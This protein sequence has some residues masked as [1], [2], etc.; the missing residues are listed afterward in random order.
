[1]P[2]LAELENRISLLEQ[3]LQLS[4]RTD[5]DIA[6]GIDLHSLGNVPTCKLRNTGTQSINDQTWTAAS[7]NST[8]WDTESS[9]PMG[10]LTNNR[11]NI[12]VGGIYYIVAQTRWTAHAT[13]A[14]SRGVRIKRDDASIIINDFHE[15][16]S[17]DTHTPAISCSGLVDMDAMNAGGLY[18]TMEVYQ[19]SGAALNLLGSTGANNDGCNFMIVKVAEYGQL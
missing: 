9:L 5:P 11:I 14:R 12:P 1:M 13:D 15:S 8:V 4:Q 2:T 6:L 17:A 18:L 7:F 3:Q 19:Y 16:V 10:D